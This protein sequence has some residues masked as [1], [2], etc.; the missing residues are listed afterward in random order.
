MGTTLKR[1]GLGVLFAYGVSTLLAAQK[2]VVYAP[3]VPK[4]AKATK[5]WPDAKAME[6]QQQDAE[7][8][9]LFQS[10]TPIAITLTAN[11]KAVQGDRNPASTKTFPATLEYTNDDGS[12]GTTEVAIRTRG[13]M[14]RMFLTCDFAPLRV[15]FT[16]EQVKHS[17]FDAQKSLKLGTHCREGVKDFEQYVLREYAA[18]RIG[19]LLTPKS[20]R[21]RLARV[22]YVDPASK[23]R[24]PARYG[25]FIEDD[26]D[27]AKRLGG[28]VTEDR[29]ALGGFSKDD[30]TLLAL[31][32]YLIG[33]LDVS[34]FTQHNVVLVQFPD[35]SLY[36]VPY[37]FDYSG[38]V[39]TTYSMPPVGIKIASTRERVYRGPCRTAEELEPFFAKFRAI[40]PQIAPIFDS[41]TDMDPG[42]KR[43]AVA[44]LD[45][46]YKTI[47]RPGDVKQEFLLNCLKKG[48]M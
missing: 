22:S 20:F 23:K 8:R 34:I 26:T 37:D 1:F 43:R 38:L 40:R 4:K 16:K 25:M 5:D 2:S 48:L 7:R 17:V 47:D 19:N 13:H 35:N 27:V 21:A 24:S 42:A 12:P 18:Y 31:F 36:P 45:Q 11:F 44:F 29:A 30:F 14:R 3:V 41:L 46:F 39:D 9:K 6:K 28:R 15:E 33:N 32:E 10:A